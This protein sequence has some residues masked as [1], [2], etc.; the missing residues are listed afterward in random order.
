MEMR[1]LIVGVDPGLNSA[2]A[3][4]DLKGKYVGHVSKKGW[5]PAG[6]KKAIS[7]MGRP[8]F[9]AVDRADAPD[10]V[11]KI[12]ASFNC[13]LFTPAKDLGVDEKERLAAEIPIRGLS[14]HEA[15]A[16]AAALAAWKS[17]ANQFT[18]IDANLE[19]ISMEDKSDA[20]KEMIVTGRA[21][22]ISESLEKLAPRPKPEPKHK[23]GPVPDAATAK[24]LER[25]LEIRDLY[26]KKLEDK[27]KMLEKRMEEM[28]EEKIRRN[29]T[30]RARVYRDKEVSMREG[31]IAQLRQEL[32]REK[33]RSEEL[34]RKAKI[35][36]EREEIEADGFVP[37]VP[38][39][40]FNRAE[41]AAA[42]AE[43]GL[44]GGTLWVTEWSDS[45]AATTFLLALRP[46]VVIGKPPLGVRE[47]LLAAAIPVAEL[48]P[49][50]D[51]RWAFVRK[52]ELEAAVKAGTK[53]GFMGW[54][55]EYR[56]RD[57]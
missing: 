33:A 23:A 54:L 19:A 12:A 11:K 46:S 51:R 36:E 48:E 52:E 26:I 13:K 21:K 17:V 43:F 30:D 18:K 55:K 7:D 16:L 39:R 1:L 41:L 15:D 6:I 2:I 5:T 40:H 10:A 45:E 53:K 57:I 44:K 31:M 4:L 9:I 20:I 38:V 37:V 28:E 29:R 50:R 14:S 25:E 22:N 3:A 56:K 24:R 49:G 35:R 42:D 34:E 27:V 8:L 32:E 47:R